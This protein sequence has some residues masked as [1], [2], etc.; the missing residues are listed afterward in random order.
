MNA[1][2]RKRILIAGGGIG[3]LT[4]A[5][6][7]LRRG[8]EVEVYEQAQALREVG[9]GLHVSSNGM[10]VLAALG[11]ADRA[12]ALAATPR[13]REIRLWNTGQS[14][15]TFDPGAEANATYGHPHVTMYRPDLL[16]ILAQAVQD[17]APTAI[18]LGRTVVGCTQ[19]ASGAVLHFT[20]GNQAR[21]DVLVGADGIHSVIRRALHGADD[22]TFTGLAV[23]RGVI[24]ADRLPDD[25]VRPVAA[26]WIGP[27]RHVVQY[28]VRRGELINFGGVVE[29]DDWHSESWTTPGTHADMYRDFTGW[30]ADIR[31]LIGAIEQPFVWALKLRRPLT[32]WSRG[33]ITLLGDACHPT[34]PF[35][36]QGA[37]MAI[38]DAFVLARALEVYGSDVVSA[39]RAYEAAR[40]E[41]T[42][43]IVEGSAANTRRFHNPALADPSGA[44]A[45]V[46][47][48]FAEPRLRERFDWIYRYDASTV[49]V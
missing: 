29:R 9:A 39:L 8:F 48:E 40:Q 22:A 38:E 1:R 42:A 35:L 17:A 45:Y 28:P 14:W 30:H 11:V 46:E 6:A 31:T 43:R 41:R 44:Q 2:A 20:D 7:L 37:V 33:R 12:M 34:L 32:Q 10:L 23:W 13:R 16:E 4:L 25:L 19:D 49:P 21:G 24:P 26:N 15:T 47:R 3:G 36:A 18:R 27:G 5:L